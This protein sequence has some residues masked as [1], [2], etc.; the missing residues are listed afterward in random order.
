MHSKA[1]TLCFKSII[2]NLKPIKVEAKEIKLS[3]KKKYNIFRSNELQ[4]SQTEDEV[5][6][7]P[8]TNILNI[9]KP[10]IHVFIR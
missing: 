1:V 8:M 6:L 5:E 3:W 9:D 2:S 4:G 7:C 10:Y